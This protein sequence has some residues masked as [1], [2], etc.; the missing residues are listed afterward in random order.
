MNVKIL[1]DNV[2]QWL[3]GTVDIPGDDPEQKPDTYSV[4]LRFLRS[5]CAPNYTVFSNMASQNKW[6]EDHGQTPESHYVVSLE[7]PHNAIHLAVGGFYQEGEFNAGPIPGANGDMGDN[8]TASFDPIFWFHHCFIDYTFSV[9]QRV[10]GHTKRGSLTVIRDYPGTILR[11]GQPPNYP[12]GTQIDMTTPLIPFEKPSGGYYTS[13]DVTDLNELG[14]TYAPGS[15]DPLFKKRTASSKSPFDLINPEFFDPMELAGLIAGSDPRAENPFPR[16][17]WV[18][19]IDRAQYE[20]SFV[21]RLYAK[22]HDGEEVE[23]GREAVLSRWN[24]KK[25][26]NCQDHLEVVFYVPIDAK[27]LGVLEGPKKAKIV[28]RVEVQTRDGRRHTISSPPQPK[29][30]GPGVKDLMSDGESTMG[31]M[32]LMSDGEPTMGTMG[33]TPNGEPT[34][35]I[36]APMSDGGRG[37]AMVGDL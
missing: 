1:N 9:W 29:A 25:C 20:G 17:K 23:M 36:V 24:A 28:W 2:T 15:L 14:I 34:M 19:N 4:Q 35:G 11:T 10:S 7:S 32:G 22:G 31:T 16:T 21:V 37:W 13:D 8:E 3:L 5:L 6:I 30:R 12:R 18:H 26:R 33:L 27:T